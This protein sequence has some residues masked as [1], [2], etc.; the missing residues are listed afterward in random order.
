MGAQILRKKNKIYFTKETENAIVKY[1]NSLDEFEREYIFRNYIH[2]PLDK[3][4]ENIINRFKFPYM[5]G[6]FEDIKSEVISFLVLNMNKYTADKGKAFSYFSVIAK[7]YLILHNNN[8]YKQEKRN[9]NLEDITE[10]L[11]ISSVPLEQM[12]EPSE[13]DVL[14]HSVAQ[15]SNTHDEMREFTVLLV[16]FLD[17][18][19]TKI[20]KKQRDVEIANAISEIIRRS[21]NLDNFNKKALYILVR[22]ITNCKTSHITKV[23][24]R[25]KPYVLTHLKEYRKTGKISDPSIFFVYK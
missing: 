6:S 19:I 17:F 21:Y 12:I 9:I 15:E 14:L 5:D 4:V 10:G 24:N 16:R 7:N 11:D 3:L 8:S 13:E 22:E 18:N 25:L 23:V 2:Q 1:N 20:F